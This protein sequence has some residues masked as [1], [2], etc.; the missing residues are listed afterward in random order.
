M[1]TL[2]GRKV[3][4]VRLAESTHAPGLGSIGPAVDNNSG[5]ML[6]AM[7]MTRTEGGVFCQTKGVSFEIPIGNIKLIVYDAGQDEA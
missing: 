1:K 6:G 5:K 4:L 2:N 7:T 3:T